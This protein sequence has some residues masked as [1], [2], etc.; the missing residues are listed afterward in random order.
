MIGT[1]AHPAQESPFNVSP[2]TPR[3]RDYGIYT[4]RPLGGK[5]SGKQDWVGLCRLGVDHLQMVSL[6]RVEMARSQRVFPGLPHSRFI[7]W[8]EQRDEVQT[9]GKD[10]TWA[11]ALVTP[12]L[13]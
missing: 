5:L 2:F 7:R 6:F 12:P 8:R 9:R 4:I 10:L 13:R 1:T 3:Y 11:L